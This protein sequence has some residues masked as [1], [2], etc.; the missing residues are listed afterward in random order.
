MNVGE[1]GVTTAKAAEAQRVE[2]GLAVHQGYLELAVA[3]GSRG[4]N[5]L[6]T[7]QSRGKRRACD[8]TIACRRWSGADN[9]GEQDGK[10]ER[11]RQR[12][13]HGSDPGHHGTPL[14]SKL[15]PK[16]GRGTKYLKP[17]QYS[18]EAARTEPWELQETS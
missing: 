10:G 18:D 14:I 7:A 2:R 4:G 17:T 16:E 13:G 8:P 5:L 9:Q 1:Q 6:G 12:G 3:S 11:Y 15:V